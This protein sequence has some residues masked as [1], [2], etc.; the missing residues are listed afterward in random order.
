MANRTKS[1]YGKS[2]AILCILSVPCGFVGIW[3][4]V[5][6]MNQAWSTPDAQGTTSLYVKNSTPI[7]SASAPPAKGPPSL[8]G[9]TNAMMSGERQASTS[10]RSLPRIAA[11]EGPF[12]PELDASEAM[13]WLVD[14]SRSDRDRAAALAVLFNGRR[15]M[16]TQLLARLYGDLRTIATDDD[17]SMGLAEDAVWVSLDVGLILLHKG[18]WSVDELRREAQFLF[19]IAQSGTASDEMRGIALMGLGRY[20]FGDAQEIVRNV[21]L[22][23]HQIDTSLV[24]RPAAIALQQ[25]AGGGAV[26]A[27][28]FTLSH[29]G[30]K[31]VRDTVLSVLGDIGTKESLRLLSQY[32]GA[33]DDKLSCDTALGKHEELVLTTLR[34]PDGELVPDA[35]AATEG[36]WRAEQVERFEPLLLGL[37][38]SGNAASAKLAADRLLDAWSR[39]PFEKEAAKLTLLLDAI[40]P[41][42][43]ELA[44][45]RD[46]ALRRADGKLLRPVR[47]E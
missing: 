31:D 36:L 14:E 46:E 15:N 13:Q 23:P 37:V 39:L 1:W 40:S 4:L 21:L 6:H 30:K 44:T 5:E 10:K 16:P 12:L 20:R 38:Q 8:G 45:V 19:D 22:D 33:A 35:I 27:L 7:G 34:E 41:S 3:L 42:S 9:D 18:H 11:T 24:A 25:I 32:R 43:L 17:E 28:E 29:S 47:S 2:P 26:E